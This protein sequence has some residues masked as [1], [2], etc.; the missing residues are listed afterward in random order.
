MQPGMA[1]EDLGGPIGNGGEDTLGRRSIRDIPI[2]RR[3]HDAPPEGEGRSQV[4]VAADVRRPHAPEVTP[5][6]AEN[7]GDDPAVAPDIDPFPTGNLTNSPTMS[8]ETQTY[9]RERRPKRWGRIAGT[10][11]VLALVVGGVVAATWHSATIAISEKTAQKAIDLKIPLSSAATSTAGTLAYRLVDVSASASESLAATGEAAVKT[12]ASGLITIYNAYSTSDQPLVKNTRFETPTGLVFRIDQAVTVP[13]GTKAADGSITPGSVQAKVVA[14]QPGQSYNVGP[15]PKF[16]VPGFKGQPQYDGFYAS[17][18][19]AMA[20]GFDGVQKVPDP[21]AESAAIDRV[22][23]ALRGQIEQKAAAAGG[24][25]LIAYLVPGTFAVRSTSRNP[26]GEKVNVVVEASAKTVVLSRQ[27][28]AEEVAASV[29]PAYV[30]GT[31]AKVDDW[32]ALRGVPEGADTPKTLALS[33]NAAVTWSVD[34]SAVAEALVGKSLADAPKIAASFPGLA[35][36]TPVVRP[37][38]RSS[39]PDEADKIEVTV[40]E[41]N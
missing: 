21:S 30:R 6:P 7:F 27:A 37:F 20:G 26:E 41:A 32:T 36:F 22:T 12:K 35:S 16:T 18:E 14:D 11:L 17:S 28:L 3:R 13:G 38:W 10:V 33:G 8:E 9:R 39:F 1:N 23:E 4:R 29:L 24:D 31:G 19:S 34:P 25:G 40:G 15:T 2:P 5:A